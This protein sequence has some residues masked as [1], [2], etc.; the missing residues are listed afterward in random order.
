MW[1]H[2][3]LCLLWGLG[4]GHIRAQA[5]LGLTTQGMDFLREFACTPIQ[6]ISLYYTPI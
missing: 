1:V 4:V 5:S 6:A 2:R 3:V